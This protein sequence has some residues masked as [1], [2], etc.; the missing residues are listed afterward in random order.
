[1]FAKMAVRYP[2]LIDVKMAAELYMTMESYIVHNGAFSEVI[3]ATLGVPQEG[4]RSGEL[5]CFFM[6]DLPDALR[7]SH[8]SVELFD[9]LITCLMFMDDYAIPAWDIAS[10]QAILR[11]L[12]SYG[13]RW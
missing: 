13:R 12:N 9:C 6:S 7:K 11:V 1:M 4:V 5:F 2:T 8:A 3:S 10:V